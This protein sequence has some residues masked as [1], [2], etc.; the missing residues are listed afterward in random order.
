MSGI[1]RKIGDRTLERL[2]PSSTAKA[3]TSYYSYC[4]CNPD[5]RA[6]RKLCHIVGGYTSCGSCKYYKSC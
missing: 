5:H 4:Y 2:V 6:Y 1:L 3:D